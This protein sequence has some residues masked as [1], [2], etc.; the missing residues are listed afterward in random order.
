MDVRAGGGK[1]GADYRLLPG[2]LGLVLWVLL[3]VLWF[4]AVVLQ[5]G[6]DAPQADAPA[7]KQASAQALMLATVSAGLLS[8]S[9]Q[10]GCC[11]CTQHDGVA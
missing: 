3:V 8:D 11:D 5:A 9:V 7:P 1:L 6:R 2:V 10:W 4:S